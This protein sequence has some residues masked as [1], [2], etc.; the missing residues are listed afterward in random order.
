M[1]ACE[2]EPGEIRFY[3]DGNLYHTENNWFTKK[4]GYGEV[5]YPAPYDQPFYMILNLAVGGNWPGNPT[6]STEFG[7][8]ATLRVDYVKVYQKDSYDENVTKPVIEQVFSEPDENGNY[9]RNGNFEIAE[10]LEGSEDWKF[11]LAG[12]GVGRAEIADGKINIVCVN[13]GDLDY[14]IQLVQPKLPMICG[15]KYKVTFDAYAQEERTMLV[16]ISAPDR[17]WI[18]YFPDTKVELTAENQTYEY[19]FVMTEDDDANGRLEFNMGNQKS[20]ADIFISNVKVEKIGEVDAKAYT[21]NVL[22]DGNYIYNG[23]FGEGSDRMDYWLTEGSVEGL[24]IAVTNENNVRELQV[25][26]PEGV[27]A[28]EEVCVKQEDVALVGGKTYVLS[29]DAYGDSAKTIQAQL[30]GETFDCELTEQKNTL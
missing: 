5:T 25:M 20:D 1:F 4:T 19:E 12:S 23:T 2:W 9:I 16:G 29:F 28:L 26:V 17:G 10:D 6:E 22:P 13:D 18:R 7:E 15:N 11:L 27:T 3:V 24:E 30:A 14:S 8:N 21:K